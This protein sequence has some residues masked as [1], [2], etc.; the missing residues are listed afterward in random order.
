MTHYLMEPLSNLVSTPG[1]LLSEAATEGVDIEAVL[2]SMKDELD[3]L[4]TVKPRL[5]SLPLNRIK[6]IMKSVEDVNKLGFDSPA[7]LGKACELF[8]TELARAAFNKT[9]ESNR[10][11]LKKIDIDLAVTT[12][13]MFDFL[14]DI[15][16]PGKKIA[17]K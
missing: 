14:L 7:V 10:V 11:L 15:V 12:N 8:I 6:R 17:S 5:T 16:T 1:L 13:E 9:V 3:G 4:Q 2:S